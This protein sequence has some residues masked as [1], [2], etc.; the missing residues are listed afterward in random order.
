MNKVNQDTIIFLKSVLI[1]LIVGGS[2]ISHV[3]KVGLSRFLAHLSRR[4]MMSY[5]TSPT[6]VCLWGWMD[7]C[8]HFQTWYVTLGTPA[9][10]S[11]LK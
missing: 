11:L 8:P 6:G 10:H 5:F 9:Y 4:L 2:R 7:V 1:V 3:G